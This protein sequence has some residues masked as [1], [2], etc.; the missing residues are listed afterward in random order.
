MTRMFE[1][2]GGADLLMLATDY[3]HWDFDDPAMA[4]RWLGA[5]SKERVFCENAIE[6]FNLPA[7]R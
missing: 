7:Q 5:S 1:L 3:P 2:M 6:W 4:L